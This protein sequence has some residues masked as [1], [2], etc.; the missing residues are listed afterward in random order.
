LVL[1]DEERKAKKKNLI[2]NNSE[3]IKDVKICEIEGCNEKQNAKGFCKFHYHK[4]Y[5][6]DNKEKLFEKNKKYVE[7][8]KDKIK[9]YQKSHQLLNKEKNKKYQKQFRSD[10]QEKLNTESRKY[11]HENRETLL[12]KMRLRGGK[13][14][15]QLKVDAIS[16]YSNGKNRCKICGIKEIEFLTL[17]HIE[18]RENVEHPKKM[19]GHQL[20]YWLKKRNY[21]PICQVLC[22]NCNWLKQ[23]DENKKKWK[24]TYSAICNRKSKDKIKLEIFSKVSNQKNP[25]CFCCGYSNFEALSLDHKDGRENAGHPKNNSWGSKFS[26]MEF[27]RWLK[28]QGYPPICQV[29]CMNCNLAKR[30]NP[31]CPHERK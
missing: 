19:S 1:T 6:E 4:K 23:L 31:K 18:G 9:A 15:L 27:W 3:K 29:F 5:K 22:M 2:K 21:P 10:N 14:M 12:P 20:C 24:N 7:K 11:H 26:G 25:S 30:D 13:R 17:D 28:K 8:N 16:H